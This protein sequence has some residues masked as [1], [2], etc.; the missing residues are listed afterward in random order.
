M[1]LLAVAKLY[2]SNRHPLTYYD[3]GA[4]GYHPV[5]SIQSRRVRM[6]GTRPDALTLNAAWLS[7]PGQVQTSI[8]FI[9]I[10]VR[11]HVKYIFQALP[12]YFENGG[13]H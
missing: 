2:A 13:F 12:P 9:I 4:E 8:S 10:D 3:S 11:R 7:F 6:N 1:L 5:T